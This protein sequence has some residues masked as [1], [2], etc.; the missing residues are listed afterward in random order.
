MVVVVEL[1]VVGVELF[2]PPPEPP[3]EPLHPVS[4]VAPAKSNAKP[5]SAL[6]N[7]FI[8]KN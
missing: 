1:V 5:V 4:A 3:P 6:L 2:P 8:I 7:L